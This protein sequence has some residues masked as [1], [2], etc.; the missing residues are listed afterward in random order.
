MPLPRS[1]QHDG[2]EMFSTGS[3][4]DPSFC[5][6]KNS[7]FMTSYSSGVYWWEENSLYKEREEW[8]KVYNPDYKKDPEIRTENRNTSQNLA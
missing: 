1:I 3:R 6:Q 8:H 5:T 2:G 7:K 4:V